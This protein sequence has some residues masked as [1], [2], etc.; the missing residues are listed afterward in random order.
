MADNKQIKYSFVVDQTSVQQAQRIVRDLISDFER[1]GKAMSGMVGPQHGTGGGSPI[2]AGGPQTQGTMISG[3][4]QQSQKGA[5]G[6]MAGL[7]QSFTAAGSSLKNL[8]GLSQDSMRMMSSGIINAIEAQKKSIQSL[9]AEIEKVAKSYDE[10]AQKKAHVL[11]AGAKADYAERKYGTSSEAAIG[12]QGQHL[13]LVQQRAEQMSNLDKLKN[14]QQELSPGADGPAG[15]PGGGGWDYNSSWFGKKFPTRIGGKLARGAVV[16]AAVAGGGAA[17]VDEMF[18]GP[19]DYLNNASRQGR[20]FGRMGVSTGQG[21]LRYIDALNTINSDPELRK[22]FNEAAGQDIL[23]GVKNVGGDVL[24]LVTGNIKNPVG[25]LKTIDSDQKERMRNMIE[26]IPDMNPMRTWAREKFESEA[27]SRAAA[28][29]RMGVSSAGYSSLKE[30]AGAYGFEDAGASAFETVRGGGQDFARRQMWTAMKAGASGMNMTVAGDF[31]VQ[32]SASG[33]GADRIFDAVARKLDAVSAENVLQGVT[34]GLSKNIFGPTSGA[35][36]A[37]A[38]TSGLEGGSPEEVYRAKQRAGALGAVSQSLGGGAD[39]MGMS[40]NMLS[41]ISTAG[42]G[43]D[44]YKVQALADLSKDPAAMADIMAGGAIPAGLAAFGITKGD[45]EQMFNKNTSMDIKARLV[46][47]SSGTNKTAATLAMEELADKYGG[48]IRAYAK[49]H[50][51]KAEMEILGAG[52]KAIHPNIAS[53]QEGQAVVEILGNYGV[54]LDGKRGAHGMGMVGGSEAT[55]IREKIKAEEKLYREQI[56]A[57]DKNGKTMAENL[58]DASKDIQTF[59]QQFAKMGDLG[60]SASQA[61]SSLLDLAVA[62]QDLNKALGGKTL[63]ESARRAELLKARQKAKVTQEQAHV[64]AVRAERDE[65]Q[66]KFDAKVSGK[67]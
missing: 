22:D 43:G 16:G 27:G 52:Y 41:A 53:T 17:I 66:R 15:P 24:G 12:L 34:Q 61:T 51:T 32:S 44:L 9:D 59:A 3:V 54:Q 28:M 31:L 18:S 48:D 6:G 19:S 45:V 38:M 30:S 65:N 29:R 57:K 35:G 11:G 5:I 40:I 26:Q 49:D 67:D 21:S 25:G 55:Y 33:G 14:E 50:G 62:A 4:Q 37:A 13:S 64:K 8:A 60:T 47:Q 63:S 2:S 7:A 36:L 23:T 1:L 56:T 42:E 39:A 20:A 58:A 10:L 46:R